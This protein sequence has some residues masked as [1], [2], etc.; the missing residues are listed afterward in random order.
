MVHT[1]VG[2]RC[3]QCAR[4]TRL[5]TFEVSGSYMARAVAAGVVLGVGGGVGFGILS[6]TPLFAVPFLGLA[7]LVAVGYF[8]GEGISAAVNQK[9]GRRLKYVAGGSVLLAYSIIFIGFVSGITI[10]G[11]LAAGVAFYVAMNRF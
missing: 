9:R 2:V 4:P 3:E 8:I 5:P 10:W 1:P 11:L 6:L 7:A